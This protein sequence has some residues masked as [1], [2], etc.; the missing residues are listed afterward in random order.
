MHVMSSFFLLVK[1]I[2][3]AA[4]FFCLQFANRRLICSRHKEIIRDG[5]KYC[6]MICKCDAMYQPAEKKEKKTNGIKD[7]M[8]RKILNIEHATTR[9]RVTEF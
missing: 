5:I 1:W 9:D 2:Q 3:E 8:D 4:V 6:C 7:E